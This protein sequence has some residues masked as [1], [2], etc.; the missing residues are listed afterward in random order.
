[1]TEATTPSPCPVVEPTRARVGARVA[2]EARRRPAGHAPRAPVRLHPRRL[3]LPVQ[4]PE[5]RVPLHRR[6]RATRRRIQ[7]TGPDALSPPIRRRLLART[8]TAT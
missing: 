8:V 4:R 3:R 2:D 6:T 7:R 1:V 5:P